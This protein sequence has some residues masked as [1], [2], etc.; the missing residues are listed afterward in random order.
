MDNQA[1]L[2]EAMERVAGSKSLAV[3]AIVSL[4]IHGGIFLAYALVFKD[5]GASNSYE[6]L[7]VSLIMPVELRKSPAPPSTLA[8]K[9]KAQVIQEYQRDIWVPVTPRE[10]SKALSAKGEASP[11]REA[12]ET[13]ALQG[14]DQGARDLTTA[15]RVEE[16]FRPIPESGLSAASGGVIAYLPSTGKTTGNGTNAQEAPNVAASGGA[17]PLSGYAQLETSRVGALT[18]AAPRYNENSLPDYPQPARRRGYTGVV[19]L[20]V[21]VLA[22]GRVGRLEMK[23]TSGH[24][25]LDKSAQETVKGWKFSPG[26]KMGVPVS[27]WVD[28]PV[29]FELN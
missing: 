17:M 13:A 16:H 10:D 15:S 1:F 7:K 12:V 11:V 29:R 22:D 4:I 20:S 6:P 21:E 26:K 2:G 5:A 25:L 9:E 23:K 19:M 27:M 14:K 18:Y 8:I 3:A 24:D 28:V